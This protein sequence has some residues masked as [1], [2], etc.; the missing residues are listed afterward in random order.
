MLKASAAKH[1][2]ERLI[3]DGYEVCAIGKFYVLTDP[4]EAQASDRLHDFLRAFGPRDHLTADIAA[5]LH[6]IGR[7]IPL[8]TVD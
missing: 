6:R 2:V 5:H 1:F 7:Y 8:E 3:E 4:A